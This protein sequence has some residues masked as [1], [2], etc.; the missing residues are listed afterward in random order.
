MSLG[1]HWSRADERSGA[2]TLRVHSKGEAPVWI[3]R[4]ASAGGRALLVTWLAPKFDLQTDM[5]TCGASAVGIHIYTL[6]IHM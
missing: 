3:P 4:A 6:H 5:S 2:E 1:V